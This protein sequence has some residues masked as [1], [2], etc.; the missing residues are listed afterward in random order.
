MMEHTA[1]LTI[2]KSANIN[3]EKILGNSKEHKRS[4]MA[5]KET[6]TELKITIKTRDTTALRASVNAVMRDIQVVEQSLNQ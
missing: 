4:S 5:V 6:R 3:Y 1:V 2:K